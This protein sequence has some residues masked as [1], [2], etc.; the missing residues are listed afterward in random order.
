MPQ[1]GDVLERFI[2]ALVQEITSTRPEYLTTPFTVAEIYQDLVPYRSH[3][4]LIGVEM[5]GDYE[6]ALLQMLS[7]EGDCLVLDSEVAR[8][9]MQAE[10][11]TPNP[12][13]GLFHEFAAAEVRLHPSRVPASARTGP[14]V[15]PE[16]RAADEPSPEPVGAKA[17][18]AAPVGPSRPEPGGSSEGG[19]VGHIETA[20]TPPLASVKVAPPD[21]SETKDAESSD[22]MRVCHWCREALPARDSIHFCPFCGSDLRPSPCRKCGEPMEARWQFCGSCGTDVRA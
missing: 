21:R 7:G 13:T 16:E 11:A 14:E 2:K 4:A 18:E 20:S 5:N 19:V 15:Q 1:S 6:E 10:L 8:R 9:E 17:E 12:N 3:R 22:A